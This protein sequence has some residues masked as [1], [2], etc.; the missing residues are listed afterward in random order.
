MERGGEESEEAIFVD[1]ET[2]K[3][4]VLGECYKGEESSDAAGEEEG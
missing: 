1:F 3:E 4:V 2:C